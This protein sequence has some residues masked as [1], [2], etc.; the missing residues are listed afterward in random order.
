MLPNKLRSKLETRPLL[1]VALDFIDISEAI[2]IAEKV[3]KAGVDILEIGTPLIKAEG[4]RRAVTIT[5]NRFPEAI[6][7]A[8]MKTADV[9][10]LEVELAANSG[11]DIVTVLGTADDEVIKSA[12]NK[13]Q[14]LGVAIEIDMIGH[15]DPINRIKRIK[16]LGADIVGLHIGIDVQRQ[17]GFTAEAIGSLIKTA[18]QVFKGPIAIAGG[19]KP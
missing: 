14:E 15:R 7:L 19:L 4:V 10:A 9:G 5:R 12:I 11:A 17:R 2:S 18:K 13:A 6:I 8:D 1:Q 3:W 16:E